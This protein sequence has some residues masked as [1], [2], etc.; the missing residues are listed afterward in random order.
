M[1]SV[2]FNKTGYDPF[3]DYLKGLCIIS[4]V[5]THS[6]PSEWQNAIGFPFWGAQAVPIF[7]IIQS[8][9]YLKHGQLPN[10]NLKKMFK[11]IVI[12]FVM[13]QVIMVGVIVVR[14]F[15]GS[16]VL[17][18]PL[19]LLLLSGGGGPGSYYFWI[20]LQFALILLPLFGWLQNHFHM[21]SWIWLVLFAL[22]S[23]ASEILCSISNISQN[24]YRILA[25]RYIFLIYGGY[26]W[27][28]KGIQFNWKTIC[29]SI[30]SIVAIVL[31]QYEKLGCEPWVFD[32][33]WRYF[34]WFC[35]F[36][37]IFLLVYILHWIYTR[38][39]G[40]GI[41]LIINNIGKRS[42][43]IFISQMAVFE[44][45]PIKGNRWTYFAITT[46][47][48]IIPVMLYFGIK[49]KWLIIKK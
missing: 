38:T 29:L 45:Y 21:E 26:I 30:L 39:A 33:D 36:W 15:L 27:A 37:A 22:L 10:I 4:V 5:L 19:T 49:E 47:L 12:P 3:I 16:G 34:H 28:K 40:G 9:H 8:F 35:Y 13:I 11:R 43:E 25:I 48:S 6:I 24:L 32:T 23:E 42:W 7:L 17:S 20:Y 14:Y 46:I 1:T 44:L 31:F 41:Q 18:T 2:T